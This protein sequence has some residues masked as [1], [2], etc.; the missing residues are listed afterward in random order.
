MNDTDFE[1]PPND[2]MGHIIQMSKEAKERYDATWR[3]GIIRRSVAVMN[4]MKMMTMPKGSVIEMQP[5]AVY[6]I[7]IL[8]L[9]DGELV[10]T[11][12][13]KMEMM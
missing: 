4:H 1:L 3:G 13:R 11:C 2:V 9:E 8:T 12:R 10:R 5:T 6:D 7:E